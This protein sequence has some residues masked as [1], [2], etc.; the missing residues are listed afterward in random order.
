[1]HLC[2]W[3]QVGNIGQ[4]INLVQTEMFLI[5]HLSPEKELMTFNPVPP[6]A[7][8]TYLK[9][10]DIQRW[11]NMNF[12][13]DISQ[14]EQVVHQSEGRCFDLR[15][16]WSTCRNVLGQDTEPQIAPDGCATGV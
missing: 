11:M 13:K 2:A 6:A 7:Q 16:L 10:V 1:M 8:R 14:V 5:R 12:G 3:Q 9:Y 15:L 4:S